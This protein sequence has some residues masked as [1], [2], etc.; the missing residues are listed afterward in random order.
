MRIVFFA[1]LAVMWSIR[2]PHDRARRTTPVARRRKTRLEAVL[3]AGA[4]VGIMVPPIAAVFPGLLWFANCE[5]PLWVSIVG[6]LVMVGSLLLFWRSH[7]DLGRNWSPTLEIGEGHT[8][9]HS[10][11]YSTIRHPMYTAICAWYTAICAWTVTPVLLLQNWIAG[12]V[13]LLFILPLYLLR[14][15]REEAMM[16]LEFGSGYKDYCARTDRRL[17]RLW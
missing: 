17:P 10:G 3:L 1:G 15:P 13:G 2:T 4:T 5:Q 14:L 11:V 8:L 6:F 12:P 7:V 16:F 9:I